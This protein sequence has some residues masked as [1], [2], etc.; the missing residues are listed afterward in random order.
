MDA[1]CAIRLDQCSHNLSFGFEL[2][3]V[4]WNGVVIGGVEATAGLAEIMLTLRSPG[5]K[6][7]VF[8]QV[9]LAGNFGYSFTYFFINI[10]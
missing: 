10:I 5:R 1:G 9:R 6:F 2:C 8:T 7:A 3:F 4:S